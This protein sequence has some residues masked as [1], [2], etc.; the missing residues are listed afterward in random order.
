MSNCIK[1]KY[2]IRIPYNIVILYCS[3]KRFIK[4]ISPSR[5]RSLKLKTQLFISKIENLITVTSTPFSKIA[6]NKKK[7]IKSIQ[8]TTT[9]LIK[10]ILIELSITT[11]RKLKLIGVGYKVFNVEN[12]PNRL[13]MFKL[14]F[15]HVLYFKIPNQ[16]NFFCL[17]FNKLFVYG[18]FYQEVN[19]I[20]SIIKYYKYP[21]PYKGKGILYENEKITLKEGKKV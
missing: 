17:K 9:A 6:N 7:N 3:K 10:Q 11:Y 14:G 2:I 12:H 21:D 1:K 19:Q 4:F 20:S 18:N 15:S 16:L 13:L 5:E 8:G